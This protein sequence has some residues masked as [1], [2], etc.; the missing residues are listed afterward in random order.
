MKPEDMKLRAMTHEEH[1]AAHSHPEEAERAWQ[2][3]FPV[4]MET[5]M[6]LQKSTEQLGKYLLQMGQMMGAMQK[7]LDEMEA[8]QAKV[9]ISHADVKRLQGMIRS[10]ADEI[11]RKYN[12][13]DRDSPKIF[14]AA[15]KK[16]VLR[17]YQVKDLHDLPEAGLAGA[18]NMIGSWVNIRL[19]MERRAST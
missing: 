18:E 3:V 1:A 8:R 16:D 5:A 14:R 9:T 17:R 4:P 12:L 10:R 11:C 2:A 15:I 6:N 7:R 19:A 13:Q